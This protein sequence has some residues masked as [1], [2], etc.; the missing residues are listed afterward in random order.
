MSAQLISGIFGLAGSIFLGIPAW[1]SLEDRR[2]IDQ[3][4]ELYK[5]AKAQA[6]KKATP[7]D[8][9]AALKDA[10]NSYQAD[11]DGVLALTTGQFKANWWWNFI[12]LICLGL[13]F[14]ILIIDALMNGTP[15]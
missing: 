11:R 2:A 8:Q 13:S 7:A 3:A 6:E 10:W 4:G 9:E 15:S 12:G 5:H 14:V 1:K